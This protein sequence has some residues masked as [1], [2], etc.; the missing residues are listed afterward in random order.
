MEYGGEIQSWEDLATA[1]LNAVNEVKSS[2]EKTDEERGVLNLR[3]L[4]L[5][6]YFCFLIKT[7]QDFEETFSKLTRIQKWAKTVEGGTNLS[8]F[9]MRV[10]NH[11][12]SGVQ[13]EKFLRDWKEE[14]FGK[15]YPFPDLIK[16]LDAKICAVVRFDT[17]P[18]HPFEMT[19]TFQCV[20]VP[21]DELAD[22]AYE[23]LYSMDLLSYAIN[24]DDITLFDKEYIRYHSKWYKS[25]IY[26]KGSIKL[27]DIIY[28]P[29][30][31]EFALEPLDIR[32][33][34]LQMLRDEKYG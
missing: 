23:G 9:A 32:K 13:R 12:V 2:L 33:K 14:H 19:K 28:P 18:Y 27:I 22:F 10:T 1:N 31:F 15:D 26:K 25:K 16:P 30:E 29:G 20:R 34:D 3:G 5:F 17:L 24:K 6:P 4:S 7:E 21:G 11:S 8:V